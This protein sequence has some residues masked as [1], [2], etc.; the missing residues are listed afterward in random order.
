MVTRIWFL[1]KTKDWNKILVK[2]TGL[3]V[4]LWHWNLELFKMQGLI[5]KSGIFLE[6]Q[7]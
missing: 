5:C 6:F 1:F 3:H 4:K 7:I 2:L